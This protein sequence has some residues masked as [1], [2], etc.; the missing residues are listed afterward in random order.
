MLKIT[1]RPPLPSPETE[2][3]LGRHLLDEELPLQLCKQYG[4]RAVVISD[5]AVE[6]TFGTKVAAKCEA[7]LLSIPSKESLKTRETKQRLE[8][9]LLQKKYGRDTVL[10]ALGGGVTTDLVGFLASTY[11]RGVPLLL[12]PTTLLAMVDASI[13]GKTGVDTPHGK[14]LV[15]TFYPPKAIV[16]DLQTL[17]TLPD[18]EWLNG[19]AEILKSGLI[20]DPSLWNLCE[21]GWRS[22]PIIEQ[23]VE[24]TAFVKMNVVQQDPLEKGMRRILNFGHTVAHGLEAISE[25][26]LPH[27]EAVALGLIIESY[28]SM[29]LEHLPQDE[30]EQIQA[31]I[32]HAG[33][34]L[35][36]PS[37]Y[38]RDGF[39]EAMTFDKKKAQGALRFTLIE[40]I[41]KTHSFDGEYC[42]SVPPKQLDEMLSYMEKHYG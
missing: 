12:I 19:L 25:F 13:G 29:R 38:T 18:K 40:K 35:R 15:G 9:E 30:F 41:G 22:A 26:K 7:E 24:K 14:N 11:L 21:K 27:G 31:K 10:I 42:R 39:L 36:L 5:A 32:S 1:L 3:W 20:A 34:S 6:K 4:Y 37:S 23:I 33:Y 17:E 8:D 28:L 16:C 2:F